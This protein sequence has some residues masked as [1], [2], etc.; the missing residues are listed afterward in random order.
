MYKIWPC[1]Q[2]DFHETCRTFIAPFCHP[3]RL[4]WNL[5]YIRRPFLPPQETFVKLVVHSSPL[6]AIPGDFLETC[7]A[8]IAPF[9]H[10][11]RLS[12]NLLY[13]YRPY[14][15][16]RVKLLN[17]F[18]NLIILQHRLQFIDPSQVTF[19]VPFW[20]VKRIYIDFKKSEQSNAFFTQSLLRYDNT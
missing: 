2:G 4:S 9:C 20:W 5:S 7:R 10:P 14:L 3:R 12:W 16:F 11:M 18:F 19:D 8:F 17:Y 15:P 1:T 6:F 13:I